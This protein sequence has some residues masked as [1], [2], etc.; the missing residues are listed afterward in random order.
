MGSIDNAEVHHYEN[1]I[2]RDIERA[3]K[4]SEAHS[5]TIVPEHPVRKLGNPAAIGFGAFALGSFMLGIKNADIVTHLPQG[6]LGVAFG[7]CSMGQFVCGIFEMVLGNTFAATTMLTYSGF[8]LSYGVTFSAGAGF[9]S[10]IKAEGEAGLVELQN[11]AGIWQIAFAFPSLIFFIGTFNQPKVIRAVLFQVFLTFI[12][13]GIGELTG[14][15]GVTKA[16]AWISFTLSI[17]A[18][19]VMT[20]ILWAEEKILHLP[21]F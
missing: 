13:G 4:H 12:L 14:S 10:A 20:A 7:F 8:W 21:M 11:V 2:H 6:I 18:W 19:Y 1:S 17:T 16:S 9:M 15:A 3:A 5:S